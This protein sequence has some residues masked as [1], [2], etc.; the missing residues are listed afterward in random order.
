[1]SGRLDHFSLQSS[2]QV[3]TWYDG[4][5]HI[6]KHIEENHKLEL[7]IETADL[8][9]CIIEFTLLDLILGLL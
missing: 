2:Q 7:I 1:M 9:V 4:H 3:L 5:V 8:T 6:C